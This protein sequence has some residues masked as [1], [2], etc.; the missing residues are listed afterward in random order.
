[1]RISLKK[2]S[3]KEQQV[4]SKLIN[5]VKMIKKAKQNEIK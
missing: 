3:K 5:N 4:L 1:M 2:L